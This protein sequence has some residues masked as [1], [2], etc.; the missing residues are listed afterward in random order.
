MSGCTCETL[1]ADLELV[2]AIVLDTLQGSPARVYLIGSVARGEARSSS[3]IDVGVLPLAPLPDGLLADLRERLEE[4]NALRVVDVVD[5][6]NVSPE[7]Q[8]RALTEGVLWSA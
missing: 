3:D 1:D 6:S 5:L 8:R 7:F 2:R 4:S